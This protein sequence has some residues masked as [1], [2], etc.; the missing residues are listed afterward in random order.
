M[1]QAGVR[2]AIARWAPARAIRVGEVGLGSCA[3]VALVGTLASGLESATLVVV[4]GL[5]SDATD[6][7]ILTTDDLGLAAVLVAARAAT[8]LL[9]AVLVARQTR[10]ASVS[11]RRRLWAA[12]LARPTEWLNESGRG[13]LTTLSGQGSDYVSH[14]VYSASALVLAAASAAAL[15]GLA[16]LQSAAV[17]IGLMAAIGAATMAIRPLVRRTRRAAAA[18]LAASVAYASG[19]V[20][21]LD[22]ALELRVFGVEHHHRQRLGE[23]SD[24]LATAMY[25]VRFGGLATPEVFQTLILAVFLGGVAVIALTLEGAEL[26]AA[27][28]AA[29]LTLRGGQQLQRAV[30]SMHSIAE[31]SSYVDGVSDYLAD[32]A[33]FT[34]AHR[35]LPVGSTSEPTLVELRDVALERPDGTVALAGVD[36]RITR[37]DRLGVIGPSGA[38]KSTLGLVLAGLLRPTS[39]GAAV[40]AGSRVALV[41]Q[42][43]HLLETSPLENVRYLRDWLDD[44]AIAAAARVA[45]LGWLVDDEHRWAN[46]RLG[47]DTQLSGG[48]AQRLGI[49]RA[50]AGEPDLIIMD[51]PTSALDEATEAAVLEAVSAI[52]TR[53]AVVMITHRP[54]PLAQ[55]DRVIEIVDGRPVV[56][57]RDG[58]DARPST[59]VAASGLGSGGRSGGDAP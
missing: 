26:A 55:C 47:R 42:E 59:A 36:L 53:T 24:D 38:G 34:T 57:D 19:A 30:T 52:D 22:H 1:S 10:R 14:A 39:G 20:T 12:H 18:R 25:R 56:D 37:G 49:A 54:A 16:A 2:G 43:V 40:L 6:A 28:A 3:A 11:V 5:V 48:E 32:S 58:Q 17:A 9:S 8:G 44:D 15:F 51:E 7:G 29:L 50:L 33:G 35:G 4:F 46:G 45:G 21:G 27:A 41:P 13:R 31:L 23:L